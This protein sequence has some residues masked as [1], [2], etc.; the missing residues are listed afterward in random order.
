[1]N[2]VKTARANRW[3]W[4]YVLL[5]A[6]LLVLCY[7][8][9]YSHDDWGWGSQY[10]EDLLREGFAGYNGRYLGN[11]MVM[12]LTRSLALRTVTMALSFTAM[13]ALIERITRGGF[14]AFFLSTLAIFAAPT[15]IFSQVVVWSAGFANYSFSVL[16]VLI[17]IKY[18][19]PLLDAQQPRGGKGVMAALFF[20]GVVSSLL[21]EHVTVYCVVLAIAVPVYTRKRLG[22][23]YP[24]HIAYLIGV[25]LAA[26][27]MFANSNY[28]NILSGESTYQRVRMGEGLIA[29]LGGSV[30]N[31]ITPWLFVDNIVL[32]FIL[33][34][35]CFVA[36]KRLRPAVTDARRGRALTGCVVVFI[37]YALYC[38]L[39]RVHPIIDWIYDIRPYLDGVVAIIFGICGVIFL[40]C[41]PTSGAARMRTFFFLCSAALFGGPFLLVQPVTARCF[42][43]SYVMLAM[44][45]IEL[46]VCA[47]AQ[48]VLSRRLLNAGRVVCVAALVVL[49]AHLLRV[50]YA[51]H[52]CAQIR[53]KKAVLD[54][55][56]G[57]SE[58]TVMRLP[59]TE[60]VWRGDPGQSEIVYITDSYKFF[61]GINPDVEVYSEPFSQEKLDEAAAALKEAGQ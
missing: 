14:V 44:L 17:Y 31:Y 21:V 56:S 34:F 42:F 60:Y 35:A 49:F 50:F 32:N 37:A 6:V 57:A 36:W 51:N 15:M 55:Y 11:L 8:F 1:M 2:L 28:Q 16:L 39:R 27:L 5:F 3:I 46:I 41:L 54:S 48:S 52:V 58:I 45:A 33:A 25:I 9:P 43:A 4:K 47:N 59:Y 24:Q 7:L 40:F 19:L 22:R 23:V 18:V 12:A 38:V 20:L 61:Y 10:G 26:I 13:I 30:V 29:K 53:T